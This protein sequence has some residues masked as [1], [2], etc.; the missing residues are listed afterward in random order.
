MM[1]LISPQK[2]SYYRCIHPFNIEK[3]LSVNN[4]IWFTMHDVFN[5]QT[6]PMVTMTETFS[7]WQNEGKNVT[8]T[9]YINLKMNIKLLFQM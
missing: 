9:V 4:F 6:G 5:T 8:L 7:F 3:S 1:C 2:Q